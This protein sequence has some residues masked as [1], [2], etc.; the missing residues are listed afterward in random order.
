VC[1]EAR[2]L[3]GGLCL[4]CGAVQSMIPRTGDAL[5][6]LVRADQPPEEIVHRLASYGAS[7]SPDQDPD[8]A[9]A[10]TPA[11]L[12][13]GLDPGFAQLLQRGLL[14][15]GFTTEVRRARERNYDLLYGSGLPGA[16]F[17]LGLLAGW[18]AVCWVGWTLGRSPGLIVALA[19]VPPAAWLLL[20]R[21]D[22]FVAPVFRLATDESALL[23]PLAELHRE[24]RGFLDGKPSM[25][26]RRLGA[27]LVRRSQV[28]LGDLE[29][30]ELPTA[31]RAAFD[32]LTLRS[33]K[34]GLAVLAALGPVEA[35]LASVDVRQLWEELEDAERRARTPSADA[36]RHDGLALFH[37]EALEKVAEVER[38]RERRCQR[39]LQLSTRL[40]TLRAELAGTDR[41]EDQLSVVQRRM[42]VETELLA[43]ARAELEHA[44]EEAR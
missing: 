11:V 28:L 2:V 33:A 26:L 22:L 37:A 16:V 7:P 24:Y 3:E 42:E 4:E 1:G 32:S 44:L 31:S 13:K 29:D 27:Q 43:S 6:V 21:A 9:L 19:A 35:Y 15:H 30:L 39:V 5:I 12:L 20:R 14:D 34:E 38:E 23:G 18:A 8:R 40:E 17:S 36:D 41:D 10:S 25:A